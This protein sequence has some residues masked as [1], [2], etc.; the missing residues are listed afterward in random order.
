M[1]VEDPVFSGDQVRHDVHK[2]GAFLY[3]DTV[4]FAGMAGINQKTPPR[5]C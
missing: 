2:L 4:S 5:S 3:Y 1:P